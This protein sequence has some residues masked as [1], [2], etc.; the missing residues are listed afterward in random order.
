VR[1]KCR[2]LNPAQEASLK[3]QLDKW[4]KAKV[5]EPSQSPWAFPMVVV[6]KEDSDRLRWCIDYHKLNQKM[7]KDAY[8]L[9]SIDGNL[10]KLQGAKYFSTLDSASAYH[11]IEI[12]PDSREYTA[13]IT[14]FG[15]Y[16]FMRMPFGLCNAGA[17]YSRLVALALQHLPAEYVLTYLDVIIVFSALLDVH[18]QQ[19]R[20]VIETHRQYGMKVKLSKCNLLQ[21]EVEYLGHLVSKAGIPMV[22]SY[23]QKVLNWPLPRT[24]K[25]AR[26]VH[27]VH[28]VLPRILTRHCWI[29]A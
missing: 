9:S 24:G 7:V 4:V 15:Q 2:P 11:A 14:P 22:P 5:A 19:L 13:F 27:G 17:C 1:E 28:W 6:K 29:N 20:Q 23:V 16:Q 21:R 25:P 10:H 8:P 26:P 3:E 18:L 12:H